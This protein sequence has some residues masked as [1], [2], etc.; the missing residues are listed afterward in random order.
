MTMTMTSD[1]LSTCRHRVRKE[2]SAQSRPCTTG[3]WRNV[4]LSFLASVTSRR[5]SS[6]A[7]DKVGAQSARCAKQQQK[8]LHCSAVAT[9]FGV[10]PALLWSKSRRR[11]ARKQTSAVRCYLFMIFSFHFFFCNLFSLALCTVFCVIIILF[12]PFHS[13]MSLLRRIFMLFISALPSYNRYFLHF[14][15]Y[16]VLYC[17][18][19]FIICCFFHSLLLLLHAGIQKQLNKAR[20]SGKSPEDA[21]LLVFILFSL[22]FYF[23]FISLQCTCCCSIY[24]FF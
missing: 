3:R 4:C 23:Y 1:V 13:S 19:W 22:H 12:V 8:R 11:A 9:T 17:L 24:C 7:Y 5:P 18:I 15:C 20:N 14:S 16:F 6:C 21:N 10:L 2:V